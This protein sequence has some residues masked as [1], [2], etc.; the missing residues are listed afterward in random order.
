MS[1]WDDFKKTIDTFTDKAVAKTREL[2]DTASLK[3]RI[4]NKEADRDIEYKKLGK[5]TYAKLKSADKRSAEELTAK[6]SETLEA[7]DKIIAELDALKSQD[8]ERKAEKEAKRAERASSYGADEDEN[9]DS[10]L[11]TDTINNFE[12]TKS[13]E[14]SDTAS[15]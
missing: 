12:S 6:I 14:S 4:A 2:T 3:I 11:N 15:L 5:L 10:E 1:K 13:G 8:D 7:L 9:D